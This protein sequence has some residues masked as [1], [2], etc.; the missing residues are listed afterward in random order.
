MDDRISRDDVH[1]HVIYL[2]HAMWRHELTTHMWRGRDRGPVAGGP[3]P[4][5]RYRAQRPP[6]VL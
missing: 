3:R 2:V 6:P 4:A 5:L 1:V